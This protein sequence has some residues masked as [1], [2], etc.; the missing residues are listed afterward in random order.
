MRFLSLF[1]LSVL[2]FSMNSYSSSK[3]SLEKTLRPMCYHKREKPILKAALMYYGASMGMEDLD[4]IEVILIERFRQATGGSVEVEIVDKKVLPFGRALP[5]DYTNG[6]ITDRNRLHRLWYYDN[7]NARITDEVYEEYKKVADKTTLQSLD[8]ILTITGA[9]FQG[10]GFANGR[11]SVTEYPQEVAWNNENGGTTNYLSDYSL[12]DELIHELGHNMFLDHTS[13]QCQKIRVPT[14]TMQYCNK[15][16]ISP[17]E[18]EQCRQLSMMY[19]RRRQE[20]CD[21]SP[22]KND[23]MSYCRKRGEVSQD[24]MYGFSECSRGVINDLVVPSM[25]SGGAWNVAGRPSCK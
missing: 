14:Q 22:S 19:L 2:S 3:C 23:V 10:L 25:L 20:C 6:N 8:A 7:V 21:N 16:D 18:K 12:V 15:P 9:Q 24:I 5:A 13:N 11:A 17:E 4:R 1:V